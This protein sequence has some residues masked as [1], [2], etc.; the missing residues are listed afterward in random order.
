MTAPVC[1][2][3]SSWVLEVAGGRVRFRR[4]DRARIPRGRRL[5]VV[6]DLNKVRDI[7][8]ARAAGGAD[9]TYPALGRRFGVSREAASLACRGRTWAYATRIRRSPNC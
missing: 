2:V 6:L 8:A 7:R 4:L 1:P 3:R 5:G 9:S